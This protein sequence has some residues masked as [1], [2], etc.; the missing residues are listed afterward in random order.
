MSAGIAAKAQALHVGFVELLS[1][2]RFADAMGISLDELRPKGKR[3]ARRLETELKECGCS[4]D[5]KLFRDLVVERRATMHRSW[6]ED[7]L[8]CHPDEAKAFCQAIRSEVGTEVPDH[9]ILRA[10]LN[11]R[12]A[13]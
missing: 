11:A 12:K 13:H 2:D 5:A 4:M 8:V 6:T 3:M 1:R 10:L 7:D 9:V